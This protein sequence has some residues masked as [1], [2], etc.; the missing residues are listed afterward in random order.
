MEL[1]GN[2]IDHLYFFLNK[3]DKHYPFTIIRPN[4]GEF[5]ILQGKHFGTQD[6]WSYNGGT[7]QSDLF[8]SINLAVSLPNSYIGIPCQSCWNNGDTQWYID[9]FKIPK[10][11]LTYG[12]IVCNKNWSI[13]TDYLINTKIP[14]YYIGPGKQNTD[15]LNVIDRYIID[16]LQIHRWDSEKE[17]FIKNIEL[18]V[19]NKLLNVNNTTLFMFSAGPLTKILIPYLFQKYPNHQFIDCGSALDLFLKGSSNRSYVKQ[20]DTYSNLVCDFTKDHSFV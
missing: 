16:E 10:E 19:D 15:K 12:N 13:F 2:S 17:Q 1:T 11:K 20:N 8:N 18:W 5:M 7:L 6:H 9:T 14:F 4:D 3:L